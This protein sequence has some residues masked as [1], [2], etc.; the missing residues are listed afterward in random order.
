[1]HA[2]VEHV[3]LPP[4]RETARVK[5]GIHLAQLAG[6]SRIANRGLGV[7]RSFTRHAEPR[8]IDPDGADVFDIRSKE[9]GAGAIGGDLLGD[10]TAGR[11]DGQKQKHA[12]SGRPAVRPSDRQGSTVTVVFD[13]CVRGI[14]IAWTGNEIVMLV[15]SLDSPP[16]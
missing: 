4:E 15:E 13:T 3:V 12:N 8:G 14:V 5:A 1:V 2:V 7:H 9:V 16:R 6:R 10:R 11:P